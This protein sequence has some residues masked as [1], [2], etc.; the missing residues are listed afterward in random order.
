MIQAQI[1]KFN[2]SD[3]CIFYCR[4]SNRTWKRI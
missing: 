4:K 1:A 3:K 2:L